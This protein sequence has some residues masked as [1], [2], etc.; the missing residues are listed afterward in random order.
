MYSRF[1]TALTVSLD[2]AILFA[3]TREQRDMPSVVVAEKL[4]DNVLEET[5][6]QTKPSLFPCRCSHVLSFLKLAQASS[7][8]S[9]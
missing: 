7:L 2:K 5:S 3:K 6:V 8:V 4:V 9:L 1:M